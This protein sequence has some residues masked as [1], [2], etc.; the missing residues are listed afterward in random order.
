MPTIILLL[1]SAHQIWMAENLRTT[2][3]NDGRTIAY[4]GLDVDRWN[5]YYTGAYAWYNNDTSVLKKTL[6][7]V[8]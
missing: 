8:I 3:Y 6:R 7:S 1:R 4:P 5:Q 2:R